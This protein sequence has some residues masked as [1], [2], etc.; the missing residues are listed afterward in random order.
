MGLLDSFIG[1]MAESAKSRWEAEAEELKAKRLADYQHKNNMEARTLTA[2]RQDATAGANRAQ[3]ILDAKRLREHQSTMQTDK[4]DL[5]LLELAR[6]A[7]LTQ[8]TEA[9][10]R[11]Y[12]AVS[13]GGAMFD[14]QTGEYVAPDG[15]PIEQGY[16]AQHPKEWNSA[17]Q[18]KIASDVNAGVGMFASG[19]GNARG[20][21][22]LLNQTIASI[23]QAAPSID[24]MNAYNLAV[25]QMGGAGQRKQ[26][27]AASLKQKEAEAYANKRYEEE[28]SIWSRDTTQ[29]GATEEGIKELWIQQYLQNGG[30]APSAA[31]PAARPPLANFNK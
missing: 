1:G 24:P 13:K 17:V 25:Q 23:K 11:R 30:A 27:A 14:S 19:D 22:Q 7:E 9:A 2:D 10:K 21:M 3:K 31:A 18:T 26:D 16:W 28:A 4:H 12:K 8:E 6:Q 15:S 5:G 20:R 29:F